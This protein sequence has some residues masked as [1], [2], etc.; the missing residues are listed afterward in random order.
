MCMQIYTKK[1]VESDSSAGSCTC[2][3]LDLMSGLETDGY[4]LYTDNCYTS[5]I[6]YTSLYQK[7]VNAY[8]TM[9]VNRKECPSDLVHIRKD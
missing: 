1:N 5:P 8:G 4:D 9:W 2:A 3:V 6:L 7:G